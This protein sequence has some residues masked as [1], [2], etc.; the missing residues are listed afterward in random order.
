MA[1][2]VTG[3][4]LN[5]FKQYQNP[6]IHLIPHLQ[7]RGEISLDAHIVIEETVQE[8]TEE[9]N[10]VTIFKMVDTIMD[11]AI[12]YPVKSELIAP[13]P[14]T[15]IYSDFIYALETYVI[16]KLSNTHPNATF[17]RF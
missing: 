4:L 5:R 17:N 11:N 9:T 10:A 8:A 16:E 13:T 2:Q 15:D 7:Y 6:Q 14:S 1:I 12:L 3:T